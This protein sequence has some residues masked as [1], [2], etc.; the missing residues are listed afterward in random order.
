MERRAPEPKPWGVSQDEAV[1]LCRAWMVY[2]GAND[3][4]VAA[5]ETKSFCNLYSHHFL[6][7]VNNS[8]HNLDIKSVEQI[9][10][11][12]SSD[13]RLPLIFVP[14]GVLPSAQDR[15]DALGVAVLRFDARNADLD[16]ANA[17][18]RQIRATGLIVT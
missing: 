3:T 8:Q 6:A 1:E 10:T 12:A 5:G 16:G 2:L 4:V 14:G 9:A 11:V 13:G 7:W 15:A 18:G 17:L